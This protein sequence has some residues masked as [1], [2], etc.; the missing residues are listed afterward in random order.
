MKRSRQYGIFAI[1]LLAA[2]ICSCRLP[3]QKPEPDRI[4]TLKE[5][6]A[7]SIGAGACAMLGYDQDK[8]DKLIEVDGKDEFAFYVASVGKID[9]DK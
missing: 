4:K 5:L 2:L 3:A 9:R 1:A 7:E 8:L 6:P